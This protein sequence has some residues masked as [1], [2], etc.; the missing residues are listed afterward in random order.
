MNDSGG[1]EPE[2]IS[3]AAGARKNRTDTGMPT[4]ALGAGVDVSAA[5]AGVADD[6]N[7]SLVVS[8]RIPAVGQER[9]VGRRSCKSMGPHG[10]S[11]RIGEN[12]IVAFALSECARREYN[13]LV[14]FCTYPTSSGHE[15]ALPS[16]PTLGAVRGKDE[17]SMSRMIYRGGQGGM[18]TIPGG[19]LGKARFA[20]ANGRPD[21]AERICRKRLERNPEDTSARVLLAQCLLQ[22]QQIV[23]AAEEAR[24]AIRE[25]PANVDAQLVLASAMLQRA[26]PLGRIPPEAEQAARRAVQLQP[27]A[28]KTHVQLAEVLAAK[29]DMAGARAEADAAIQLEPRLAGAHLMRALVLLSDNDP[30]GA[31]QASD[32]A[33]RYDRTLTQ[34]EFIKASALVEV[35][36]YDEALTSLDAAERQNPLLAGTNA[37]ALRGRI[38]FKQRKLKQSYAQFLQI[39]QMSGRLR[40]LS[41][42]I[43]G[44]NMVF[45]GFF[46]QNAQYAW[47]ALFIVII[48]AILFGISF[49]H[50]GS[51]ALGQWIVAVL[52][53]ALVGFTGFTYVRQLRGGLLPRGM[54]AMVTTLV[55]IVMA[56]VAGAAIALAIVWALSTNVFHVTSWWTP[57]AMFLGGFIGLVAA[58][59]AAYFFPQAMARYGGGGSRAAA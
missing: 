31:V 55:A 58:S 4:R 32:L 51:L 17:L 44:I 26:G 29:R 28:A 34:A 50:A 38:Y 15:N 48:L 33:L 6:G 9:G 27:K 10:L 22:Q 52:V 57:F 20:L 14:A 13:N 11:R 36:R 45:S 16:P 7:A 37:M 21:E 59:F 56:F 39:Q 42:V 25:Q 43:A 30:N 24:R 23:E 18:G 8:Y 12:P 1:V 54:G 49:I 47:I 2:S 46:G 19:P 53:L 41:P 3:P 35:K 40:W 5:G